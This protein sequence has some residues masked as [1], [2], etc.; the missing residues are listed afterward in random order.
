MWR[1]EMAILGVTTETTSSLI[2]GVRRHLFILPFMIALLPLLFL[3]R[4]TTQLP[5]HTM[6]FHHSSLLAATAAFV[7]GA[8]SGSAFA[9][10]TCEFY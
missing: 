3:G 4:Q 7:Y 9:P 2:H 6:R 10:S 5:L 8:S 1:V